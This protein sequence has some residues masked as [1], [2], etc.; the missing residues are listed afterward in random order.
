MGDIRDE[1]NSR[2]SIT[3]HIKHA[4]AELEKLRKQD[5]R[6]QK[7]V[8][9]AEELKD[10]IGAELGKLSDEHRQARLTWLLLVD[11]RGDVCAHIARMRT[12]IEK[13]Q[14]ALS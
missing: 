9:Q 7:L 2:S 4:E 1:L 6:M 13:L 11:A 10:A 3:A 14:E 5:E 12:H 8:R